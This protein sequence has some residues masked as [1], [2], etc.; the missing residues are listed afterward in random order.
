MTEAE[1]NLMMAMF[2][3]QRLLIE[4]LVEILKSRELLDKE[5]LRAFDALVAAS[6][7]PHLEDETRG[8]YLGA[9]RIFG[10]TGLPKP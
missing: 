5:D 7:E 6:S 9:A 3:Q 1:H 2:T 8:D 10:V 4:G